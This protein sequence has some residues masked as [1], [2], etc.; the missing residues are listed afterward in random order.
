MP[1]SV[2]SGA[3]VVGE[4]T[5]EVEVS[6]GL[7][8]QIQSGIFLASGQGGGGTTPTAMSGQHVIIESGLH[9]IEEPATMVKTGLIRTLTAT[10]GGEVL[11]SGPVLALEVMALD[12]NACDIYL[13]G[14]ND[15]P[16]S[17]FGYPLQAGATKNMTINDFDAV[18]LF[19][20][21]SGDQVGFI[22]IV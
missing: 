17:G 5:A 10:S 3:H 15:R 16:Y 7:H 6:S 22:G 1:V 12:T 11:H 19:P 4:F 14:I 21:C 2:K 18:Y 8:V 20:A 9:V 13:G